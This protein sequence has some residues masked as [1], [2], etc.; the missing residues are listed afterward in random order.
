MLC[1]R[2]AHRHATPFAL[3]LAGLLSLA[4][5]AGAAPTL[6][7]V[8]TFPGLTVGTWGGGAI[9]S[10][11][12]TGGTGGVPDG[13]LLIQ[14][15]NGTVHNLGSDSGGN[16]Y[17]GDWTV[18]GIT[19]VRLWLNDVGTND[20]L[21]MHF[22]IGKAF[23]N[24]WQY[25]TTF[26]PPLHQWS[27]FVVD[28]SSSANWTHIIGTGTFTQALQNVDR[29]LVR[30]DKTPYAMQ[31]D[32][33]DGDVGLDHLLLT[34]GVV[35]VSPGGS[36]VPQ[37]LSLA[38]PTPNPS[39][40]EVALAIETFEAGA[41]RLEIVDAAGRLVRHAELAAAGAGVLHWAWDGRD[42]RGRATP[43]GFYRVRAT[44]RAGGASRGLVRID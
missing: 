7:F 14:T 6:G 36:A 19:Q 21:E 3:V 26:L 22:V 10:N 25:N 5:A 1:P 16:E 30:H 42:D 29:V 18:A 8:E 17:L 9:V 4:A 31:P 24:V 37:A 20:P 27:E 2:P 11:P 43:A 44:G 39:R 41:V 15:P 12:G 13:Y 40:G 32:A 38:A 34:N 35:G 28:L 23:T 33:L